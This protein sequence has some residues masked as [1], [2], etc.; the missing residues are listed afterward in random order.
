MDKQ[1]NQ[2]VEVALRNLEE[3]FGKKIDSLTTES[4][5]EAIVREKTEAL[6]RVIREKDRL[7]GRK[8][9]ELR[10]MRESLKFRLAEKIVLSMRRVP[11]IVP[12]GRALLGHYLQRR[13]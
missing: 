1:K 7:L 13:R 5:V 10:E 9:N 12:A 11:W 2:D 8:S 6:E 4:L 3:R